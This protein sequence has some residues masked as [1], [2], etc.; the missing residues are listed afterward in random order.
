MT[1]TGPVPQIP[2][3]EVPAGAYLLDVREDEA[4]P[5]VRAA[6]DGGVIFFDTANV[7]A[8]GASE[9]VTGR[10]LGKLFARDDVVVATKVF[11][12]MSDGENDRGLSRKHVLA[13][14]DASLQ[15]L[16]VVLLQHPLPAALVPEAHHAKTDTRHPQARRAQVGVVHEHTLR[17]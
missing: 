12:P 10:L 11:M 7:Y 13:A 1:N 16:G 14:I 9:V 6:A 4:E 5:I 3:V 8:K 17:H 2:A 15:R